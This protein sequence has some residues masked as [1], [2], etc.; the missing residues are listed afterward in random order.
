MQPR[1]TC[2]TVLALLA[3]AACVPKGKYDQQVVDGQRLQAALHDAQGRAH[4]DDAELTRLRAN[5]A[6]AEDAMRD[7]DK[8]LA[9]AL[10]TTG[11]L[12]AKLDAQ[13][14]EDAQLREELR[15]LGKNAD[16]LLAE[17]GSLA[18]ALAQ[19]KARLE[20]LRNAQAAADARAALFHQLAVKF[21]K[22]VDAG[23]L[24]IGLRQGRMVLQ[25]SNDVLFD[26]GRTEIK[27]AGQAALREIASVLRTLP[28][29]RFQ[30]AG[31]T[32]NVPIDTTRFPS[33]WELSAG[34][35]LEVVHFLVAQKMS[36]TSLSAAGYGEF[37]PVASNDDAEGRSRNRRIEITLQPQI[38][39]MAAVPTDK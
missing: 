6:E 18:G 30:V 35:A 16:Q 13:T 7:R 27:P 14:A 8:R 1:Y 29:R 11:G 12:Q 2:A 39:E 19:A 25:L 9:D 33:N 36:P 22:M 31:D 26:T 5:I 15:R 38:D 17:K 4:G 32:D 3:S 24:R 10:A 21:Q 37:D 34:R 23:E 28:Q 20:E